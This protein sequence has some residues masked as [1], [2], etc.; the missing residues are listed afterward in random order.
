MVVRATQGNSH[1]LWTKYL[2]AIDDDVSAD[3]RTLRVRS[4]IPLALRDR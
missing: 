1:E 3:R 4:I 2:V